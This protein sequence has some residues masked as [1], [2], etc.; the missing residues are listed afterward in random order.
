MS[1]P[2]GL[3]TS[4]E[5]E[6]SASGLLD[7]VTQGDTCSVGETSSGLTQP[8]HC[9]LPSTNKTSV[10]SQPGAQVENEPAIDSG[11]EETQ[12]STN[13]W[14]LKVDI[15]CASSQ[16]GRINLKFSHFLDSSVAVAIEI[17]IM[18]SWLCLNLDK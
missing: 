18:R 12:V 10:Y 1:F 14:Q 2:R 3:L 7:S 4:P 17:Y 11:G 15:C 16:E 13:K 9:P 6:A 8:A 5:V